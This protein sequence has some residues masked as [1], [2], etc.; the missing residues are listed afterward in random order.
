[1]SRASRARRIATVAAY[2]GG[3][4]G[5]MAGA[6]AGVVYGQTKLARRRIRPTETPP[7]VADGIWTAPGVATDGEPLR[8][9][10]LGDSS[11]AGYGLLDSAE[12][13]AAVLARGLSAMAG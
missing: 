9:A 3:S 5:A 1:M 8:V 2:G 13:P 6:F 10:V 11:A 4:L 7:P 12:T